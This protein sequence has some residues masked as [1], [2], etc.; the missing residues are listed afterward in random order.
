M[1]SLGFFAVDTLP[2]TNSSPLKIGRNPIGKVVFQPS[3]FRGELFVS[4]RLG[5][6]TTK[7]YMDY[8]KLL[9]ESHYEPTTTMEC[10][11]GS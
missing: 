5:D 9:Y 4:G 11:N 2:E 10:Q 8:N 7:L 6:Y 3:I 1:R